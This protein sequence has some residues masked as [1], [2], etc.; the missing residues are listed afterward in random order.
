MRTLRAVARTVA[1]RP[2]WCLGV[3][4]LVVAPSS[5][6]LAGE[7]YRRR[8]FREEF[9]RLRGTLVS[10][11]ERSLGESEGFESVAVTLR[12]DLGLVVRGRI[13]A[14]A[15]P[16]EPRPA[17]L[18]LGGVGTGQETVDYID[19]TQ[20]VVLFALDYPYDGATSGLGTA[21]FLGAVPR[22]QRAVI[23][24]VPAAMLAVDYLQT[25]PDVDPEHIVLVGGSLGA[26][27][28][29]AVGA[30]DERIAGVA[31]LFGAGDLERLARANLQ[32]LGWFAAPVGWLG[33]V[34]TAAVEPLEYVE[35]IAPRPLLI[36]S[37]KGDERM[38]EPCS[39]ALQEAAGEPKTI[40]WIDTGHVTLDSTDFHDIVLDE[41]A[42]WLR[43]HDL[44]PAGL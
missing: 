44:V 20:G 1:A 28:A 37:G 18:L 31:L 29:P 6:Y 25:R 13:K 14:P 40:R 7:G 32:D 3:G 15:G 30:S 16:P 34:L 26:L 27:F 4:A 24:T 5:V 38:P 36:L 17:L 41:L 43:A 39:R 35:D 33:A 42:A 2:W 10:S 12:D 11:E 9:A 8:D 21:E 19:D 23:R 22:I